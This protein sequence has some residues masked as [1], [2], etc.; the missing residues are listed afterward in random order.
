MKRLVQRWALTAGWAAAALT[1][2]VT[3]W[4]GV[5][6]LQQSLRAVLCGLAVYGLFRLGGSVVGR[7][8]LHQIVAAQERRGRQEAQSAETP[9]RRR[10]A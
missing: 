3:G 8:V 9:E 1:A 7:M 4:N 2:V 6:P 5:S 10:A